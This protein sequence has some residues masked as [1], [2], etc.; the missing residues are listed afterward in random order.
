MA[1]VLKNVRATTIYRFLYVMYFR[2]LAEKVEVL[3]IIH[4]HRRSSV[5][6]KRQ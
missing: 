4:G 2:T 5:W 1:F 6:K 3:A